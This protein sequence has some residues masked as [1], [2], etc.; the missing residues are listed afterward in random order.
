MLWLIVAEII[1]RKPYRGKV[2][3]RRQ[4]EGAHQQS[5]KGQAE[6]GNPGNQ[7]Q[8]GLA[9]ASAVTKQHQREKRTD[10][11]YRTKRPPIANLFITATLQH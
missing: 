11:N 8:L 1:T 5:H 6:W 10:K 3:K 7:L 4:R 2:V 9:T